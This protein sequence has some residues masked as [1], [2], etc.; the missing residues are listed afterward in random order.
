MRGPEEEAH[1]LWAVARHSHSLC[2]VL[3]LQRLGGDVSWMGPGPTGVKGRSVCG[4]GN[5]EPAPQEGPAEGESQ[6]RIASWVT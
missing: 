5:G 3:K 2:L 6:L 4:A 1:V